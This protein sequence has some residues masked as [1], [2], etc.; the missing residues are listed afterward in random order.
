MAQHDCFETIV[1][2]LD[3]NELQGGVVG[4][5]ALAIFTLVNMNLPSTLLQYSHFLCVLS[6]HIYYRVGGIDFRVNL[7]QS[8]L[9]VAIFRLN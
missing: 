3:T 7:F 8:S 1:D 9:E 5:I 6:T 4:I 2:R